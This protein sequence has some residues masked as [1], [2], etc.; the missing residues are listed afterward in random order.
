MPEAGVFVLAAAGVFLVFTRSLRVAL[1]SFVAFWLLVPASLIVPHGPH[2]L[3][4]D[5][6]V[7]YAF[8]LR[9]VL[10]ARRNTRRDALG[11]AGRTPSGA[12][13]A[14]GDRLTS[15]AFRFTGVHVAMVGVLV[16]GFVDGVVLAPQGVSLA[17]DLDAWL[18]PL[19]MAVVFVA[20]LAVVRTLGHWQVVRTIMA[21]LVVTVLVGV[22][23][24]LSGSGWSHLLFEH[25][26][27]GYVAPG[28]DPLATRAGHVRAQVAAQFSLEYAW[29]L[30]MF[31]PLVVVAVLRW[32]AP[33]RGARG[34]AARPG[35]P[36][37]G[38]GGAVGVRRRWSRLGY[39]APVALVGGVALT[40]SRSAEVG[41]AGA[42][43]LLVLATGAPRR[44]T[45]AVALG[46]GLVLLVAVFDGSL[47]GSPFSAAAHTN[48]ISVRLERLPNLFSLVVHR[49]FTGLGYSGLFG[50]LP[51]LDDSYALLYGTIGVVG[52]AAWAI[53][54][55]TTGTIVARALRAPV[56]SDIR[57]LGA[58]CLVGIVA[59]VVAGAA[60]DL[61]ATPQSQWSFMILAALGVAVAEA[62]P[63]RVPA[64]RWWAARGLMPLAGVVGGAVMLVL[65]PSASAE[66][67]TVFMGTPAV[68]AASPGPIPDYTGKVLVNSLCGF[69]DSPDQ[70]VGGTTLQCQRLTDVD[71]A[72]WPTLALVRITGPT[73]TAVEAEY[74]HT[75]ARLR[76]S[77]PAE[78]AR[79]G[80]LQTGKPA[81]ATT[82]PLW[83][84]LVG[85]VAMVLVPPFTRRRL[86]PRGAS[87]EVAV[88]DAPPP[89]PAYARDGAGHLYRLGERPE[90]VPVSQ[91]PG[92]GAGSVVP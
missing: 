91:A 17:S 73:P 10:Q 45:T 28:A 56:E 43:V 12:P 84:G 33:R 92:D 36:A 86:L 62:V 4:V 70:I 50:S 58:A 65:A 14:P 60:Y 75:V 44:V 42:A 1:A 82:A 49:P 51:G 89:R 8:A 88:H 27:A 23:E 22:V 72:V 52:L 15:S 54:L 21:A 74:A 38:A 76:T 61:V 32:A 90:L 16:A 29:V 24:R 47:I 39:L 83:M 18:Y 2:I 57:D 13:R 20:V 80:T 46:I 59:V 79:V 5:R 66:T 7:L 67:S 9:M 26:P 68:I 25:M 41:V 85:L 55:V 30:A 53:V 48:S 77:L 69:L 11:G 19:D 40:A 87:L 3:L 64:R 71:P 6:L 63:R 35:A 37:A 31:L 81:W 78:Y 34:G